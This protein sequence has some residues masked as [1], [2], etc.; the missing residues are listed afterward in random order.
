[1]LLL[2]GV[3]LLLVIAGIAFWSIVRSRI[4]REFDRV[5]ETEARG[6]M[7]LTAREGEQIEAD[8]GDWISDVEELQEDEN[9]DEEG[10]DDEDDDEG[11]DDGQEAFFELFLENGVVIRKSAGLGTM[12]LPRAPGEEVIFRDVT[13]PDGD[14]GR[15]VQVAF[16]PEVDEPDPEST[17]KEPENLFDLPAEFHGKKV[18]VVLVVARDR[19][20]LEELLSSLALTLGVL[21]LLLMGGIALVIRVSLGRGFQPLDH[22]QEQVEAIGPDS[23]DQ[24]VSLAAPAAELD[25][26]VV[27]LNDLLDRVEQG[28]ERER[29]FSDDVAHEL[30]TPLAEVLTACEVG[31]KWPED[32]EA[33]RQLF[34]HLRESATH[35]RGVVTTLLELARCDSG[36]ATVSRESISLKTLLE[37]CWE[38]ATERARPKSIE[39][40]LPD[41]D[42]VVESDPDRL[43][44]IVQN[45]LDN[46]VAHGDANSVIRC[47]LREGQSRILEISNAATG[48]TPYDVRHVFDRFWQKDSSRTASDQS[49]LGLSIVKALCKLLGIGVLAELAE[50]NRFVIILALPGEMG[51]PKQEGS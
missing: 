13:L 15:L 25:G 43:R 12:D 50:G 38:R 45:L 8:Y 28:F 49:G 34:E 35:L 2:S 32:P 36:N 3:L 7:V 17:D 11:E 16:Y 40:E 41:G 42:L 24:R 39:I 14:R 6:L 27:A 21:G 29:R 46:A 10:D 4:V 37:D 23:L 5:L 31:E 22:F 30:R 1:M 44:I 48:M 26:A 47:E 51:D 9:E 18:K 19:E 33:T 20:H